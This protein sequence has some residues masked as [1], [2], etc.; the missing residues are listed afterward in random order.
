VCAAGRT[1]HRRRRG[2]PLAGLPEGAAMLQPCQ[3]TIEREGETSLLYFGGRLSHAVNKRPAAG[4]FRIQLD[5]GGSYHAVPE[6]PAGAVAL[7]E[8]PLAAIGEPPLYA[9]TDMLPDAD[10]RWLLMAAELL[11]PAFFLRQGPARP[12]AIAEARP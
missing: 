5:F 11:R 2:E 7:A 10:G 4:D 3:A 9:R 6:P 1:T 8:R 12:A